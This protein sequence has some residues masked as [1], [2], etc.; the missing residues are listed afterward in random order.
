VFRP[1]VPRQ[2]AFA[3]MV[4]FERLKFIVRARKQFLRAW[5]KAR[6]RLED[7]WESK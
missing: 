1:Q 3:L 7:L 2:L 4:L 5:R 6:A